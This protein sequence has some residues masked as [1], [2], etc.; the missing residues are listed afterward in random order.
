MPQDVQRTCFVI[1]PFGE[2]KNIQGTLLNFDRI[3][4]DFIIP[5][6]KAAGL[7]CERCDRI[8]EAGNIHR[9]MFQQI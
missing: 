4:D 2:K 3:Y 1:M 9:R 6:V 5:T 7:A 8:D